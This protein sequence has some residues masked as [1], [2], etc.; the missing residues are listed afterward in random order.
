M[1]LESPVFFCDIRCPPSTAHLDLFGWFCL[2][3][4]SHYTEQPASPLLGLSWEAP[5]LT[6]RV[7]MT[8][9]QLTMCAASCNRRKPEEQP[10]ERQTEV[11][12]PSCRRLH[13]N[14]SLYSERQ[15]RPTSIPS[16]AQ[17]QRNGKGKGQVILSHI[18][19]PRSAWTARES[20]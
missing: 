17:K 6:T 20:V 8:C 1:G 19:S 14:L 2:E 4:G 12:Q 15:R 7:L 5:S 9:S 13:W 11:R 10:R 3:T 16:T 18:V